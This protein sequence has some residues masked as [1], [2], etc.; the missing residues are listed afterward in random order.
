MDQSSQLRIIIFGATSDEAFTIV[1]SLE[2]GGYQ[3]RPRCAYTARSFMGHLHRHPFDMILWFGDAM[4]FSLE[5]AMEVLARTRNDIP[6]IALCRGLSA[7]E[8]VEA[9]AACASFGRPPP[10]LGGEAA[11]I[12]GA[13]EKRTVH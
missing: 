3:V 6:V 9:G 7:M 8:R 12:P 4:A 11:I 13:A 2:Q 10:A 1:K 5:Q